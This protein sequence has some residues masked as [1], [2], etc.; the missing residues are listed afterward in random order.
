MK[1]ADA[2]YS[3]LNSSMGRLTDRGSKTTKDTAYWPQFFYCLYRSIKSVSP[4]QDKLSYLFADYSY[5]IIHNAL[6]SKLKENVSQLTLMESSMIKGE[7]SSRLLN[8]TYVKRT[9]TVFKD[10]YRKLN[11]KKYEGLTQTG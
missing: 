3:N 4:Q 9:S 2:A 6:N 7:P 8:E 11:G 5:S 1:I 10:I